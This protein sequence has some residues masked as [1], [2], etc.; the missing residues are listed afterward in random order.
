MFVGVL[1]D[2]AV[3]GLSVENEEEDEENDAV[4]V[5]E[6]VDDDNSG[7]LTGMRM[8][9]ELRNPGLFCGEHDRE[10]KE[11]FENVF[12]S[13]AGQNY[14]E[15]IGGEKD[16]ENKKLLENAFLWSTMHFCS[17]CRE[18]PC[19]CYSHQKAITAIFVSAEKKY[20]NG[21]Q[22]KLRPEFARSQL[23]EHLGRLPYPQCLFDQFDYYWHPY[24]K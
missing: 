10:N 4:V 12:R 7:L 22:M 19:F 11:L 15:F 14:Y 20:P 23:Q 17:V 6:T 1:E 5:H 8:C 9:T 21:D 13:C 3:V 24:E 18:C 16:R 2:S